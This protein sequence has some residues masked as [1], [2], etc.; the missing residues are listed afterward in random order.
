MSRTLILSAVFGSLS[1][2]AA[3]LSADEPKDPLPDTSQ[4]IQAEVTG[5]LHFL[6]GHGYY[7]SVK[8]ASDADRETRVWLHISENKILVRQLEGL[9]DKPVRAK[10]GLE[11]MPENSGSSV[12]PKGMYMS[13]FDIKG[14]KP[15]REKD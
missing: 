13:K 11:Q 7:I 15:T 5:V 4:S 10:G 14:A 6:A 8:S 3:A 1:L 12:P 2:L 9:T